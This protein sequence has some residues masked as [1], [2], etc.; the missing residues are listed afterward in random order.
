M[1]SEPADQVAPN[2]AAIRARVAQSAERAGRVPTDIRL[3]AVS[4]AQ[5]SARIEAALAAGCRCFGE[6]RVQEAQTHW[7]DRRTKHTD[8][9]LHLVGPLQ[10][11]KV[12]T[13]V[14]LFDVIHTVD[15][16]KLAAALANTFASTGRTRQCFIEINVGEEPQKAGVL[17][18]EADDFIQDCRGNLDLP[19]VGLM[20][21]PPFNAQPAPFF[22]LL[23]QIAERNG[24]PRLS[25][26][27]S[28]DFETAIEIGA[29]DVRVGTA[30]FGERTPR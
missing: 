21:I 6:N 23:R 14:E 8:L 12:K 3:I 28:A 2:L 19:V 25:M 9:E 20:C 4:K 17:P 27:M 30:I 10:R 18:E 16:P 22:A 15:R 13:A 11:N 7:S 29:T 5:L 26:G 24:L 1:S